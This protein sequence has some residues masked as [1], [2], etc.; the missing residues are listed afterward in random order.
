MDT[1]LAGINDKKD[2]NVPINRARASENP[3]ALFM[4]VERRRKRAKREVVPHIKYGRFPRGIERMLE[5]ESLELSE[6]GEPELERL[7]VKHAD[8]AEGRV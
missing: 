1:A 4:K 8:I 2:R 7:L 6:L 3:L 5:R